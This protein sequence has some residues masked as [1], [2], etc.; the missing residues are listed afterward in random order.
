MKHRK[1]KTIVMG[2]IQ[3]LVMLLLLGTCHADLFLRRCLAKLGYAG[4]Q[5]KPGHL[6]HEKP[7]QELTNTPSAPDKE[8]LLAVLMQY[9][10]SHD[11][12]WVNQFRVQIEKIPFS[13][14]AANRSFDRHL[15]AVLEPTRGE[16]LKRLENVFTQ[17]TTDDLAH[18][19][20][21]IEK[22]GS[23]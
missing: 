11:D 4:P 13:K 2:Y 17:L 7:A 5:P 10:R 9:C 8:E 6:M 3:V 16:N 19:Q 14:M 21:G 1:V 20:T 18:V 22:I 23:F 15:Y 12:D